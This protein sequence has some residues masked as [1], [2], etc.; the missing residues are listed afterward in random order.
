[1]PGLAWRPTTAGGIVMLPSRAAPLP[2]PAVVV[3]TEQALVPVTDR[4]AD[5]LK[6]T[7]T[8]PKYGAHGYEGDAELWEPRAVTAAD[9]LALRRQL[10]MVRDAMAPGEPG[11]VLARIH[12]LLAQYRERDPL[13]PAVEAAVAEDWL[14]DVGEFPSA[15]VAEAC[16]R[17]RRHPTKYR[18]KPLPGDIR[19]ICL[20]I[21]GRLPVVASRLERLLAQIDEPAPS[22]ALDVR[23][24]VVALAAARRMPA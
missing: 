21:M 24:R 18:F 19:M 8:M 16:R 14:D 5:L 6:P 20:E 2:C 13:P 23:S 22:R 1:M 10:A 7:R 15:V 12:A 3:S 17:W 9:G 4:V 11:T